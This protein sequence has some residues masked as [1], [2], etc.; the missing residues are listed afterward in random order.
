MGS[1]CG[2]TLANLY[3]YI[4]EKH[5]LNIKKPLVYGRFI[6][7]IA[8]ISDNFDME[9]FKSIFNNLE[10]NMSG[11]KTVQFLDLNIGIDPLTYRLNFSLYIKKTNTFQYVKT[12][13]NHPKHI[14]KNVPKGLFIRM[15]RICS[16][17]SDY[18][19]HARNLIYQL[20]NRGYNPD[21]LVRIA[22]TIG[23][24]D[25]NTLIPYKVK[26]FP[27][28][29]RSIK[30]YLDFDFN[31]DFLKEKIKSSFSILSSKYEWT[32]QYEVKV[33]NKMRPNLNML[34]VNNF[35][36]NSFKYSYHNCT[37]SKC[38]TCE[39]SLHYSFIRLNNFYFPLYPILLVTLK[40]VFI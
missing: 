5:W 37:D 34:I 1:I 32:K 17:Y 26:E 36:F 39:Y 16:S 12:D 24:V 19:Y 11:G 7:D 31:Q 25:R 6:D 15:R 3:I 38:K 8:L 22:R 13:S 28:T 14:F 30:T 29:N 20:N 18:L 40:V 9:E 27:A 21:K 23:N 35:H 33:L 4:L 2:P 10:L